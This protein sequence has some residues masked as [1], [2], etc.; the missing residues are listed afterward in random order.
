MSPAFGDSVLLIQVTLKNFSRPRKSLRVRGDATRLGTASGRTL[1]TTHARREVIERAAKNRVVGG[2]TRRSVEASTET[3]VWYHACSTSS[4]AESPEYALEILDTN[5]RHLSAR[6]FELFLK[7][8]VV[9]FSRRKQEAPGAMADMGTTII[10]AIICR[11]SR[12]AAGK[13]RPTYASQVA[14]GRCFL[15]SVHVTSR[16]RAVIS[17]DALPG[18]DAVGTEPCRMADATALPAEMPVAMVPVGFLACAT[19]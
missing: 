10:F 4:R 18:V 9:A 13:V 16:G 7:E 14:W 6:M 11:G 17:L 8:K 15:L 1:E 12:N 3:R 2:R 5:M 19:A